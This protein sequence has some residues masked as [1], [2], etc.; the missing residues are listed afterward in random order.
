MW[1][2]SHGSKREQ[3]EL[4]KLLVKGGG[5][6]RSSG[7]NSVIFNVYTDVQ[8]AQLSTRSQGF[9]DWAHDPVP[10]RAGQRPRLEETG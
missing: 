6:Y 8:Y 3:T 5:L 9:A 2:Q 10:T 7:K 4:E 1:T